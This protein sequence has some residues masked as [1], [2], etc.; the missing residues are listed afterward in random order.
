MQ[1]KLDKR[2][3][4]PNIFYTNQRFTICHLDVFDLTPDTRHLLHHKTSTPDSFYTKQFWHHTILRYTCLTPD[5]FT[6]CNVYIK[7]PLPHTTWIQQNQCAKIM[8]N[9]AKWSWENNGCH[10]R[11]SSKT[12]PCFHAM[13]KW[14]LS[15][16]TAPWTAEV[17]AVIKMHPAKK[18]SPAKV[19][20]S[21][22]SSAKVG[23]SKSSWIEQNW[24]F[25]ISLQPP[26]R[27]QQKLKRAKATSNK[28]PSLQL[29]L[30][31]IV[32]WIE[33]NL[34]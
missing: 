27:I 18:W 9:A 23:C 19:E 31:S 29:K 10:E 21:K 17:M 13:L 30:K 20:S 3:F 16:K 25:T 11:Q 5:I 6:P 15:R 32:S 2:T 26:T 28:I 33:R 14:W 1:E 4:I 12:V 8:R 7:C 34:L 24:I 22:M